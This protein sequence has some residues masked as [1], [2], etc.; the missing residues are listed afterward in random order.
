VQLV[1]VLSNLSADGR[2]VHA[3]LDLSRKETSA[4]V[5]Q[6]IARALAEISRQRLQ[7]MRVDLHAR[8]GLILE[9]CSDTQ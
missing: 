5:Q 6:S 9:K 2:A 1:G 3:L 8:E 7:A 4:V